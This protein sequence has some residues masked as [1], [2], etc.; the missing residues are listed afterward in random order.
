MLLMR[1]L[2]VL[3]AGL[4][5]APAAAG[6]ARADTLTVVT[7]NLWHDQQDWPRR[8][9]LILEELRVLRPDVICLQEVL[10]HETLRNQAHDLAETL[11]YQ[12]TFAS[13]DPDTGVKRYGN[14]ILARHPVLETAWK[15]LAPLNDYRVVA[16][17][18]IDFRGRALDVFVTHLHHTAE[19]AA[20]RAEQV[21]D[22]LAYV[23]ARHGK[24]PVVLA[25]DFNAAPDA[26]ELRPVMRRYV[27]VLAA[28]HRGVAGDTVTTLNPA[29]GHAPRRIDYVFVSRDGR[30][31]LR[32][33]S[34]EV[35]FD[36]PAADG[37]WPSDHFGVAAKLLLGR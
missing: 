23:N 19:G 25:G 8:R 16:H 22:L 15:P 24:G 1:P 9:A 2:L 35:V 27:D 31:A 4:A 10:Q 37:T 36:R 17:L 3:L 6:A 30:P 29:K 20:I 5:L 11:G 14:A 28:L 13:V 34:S 26:P 33:L 32:P 7:L 21:R 12:V 18:R